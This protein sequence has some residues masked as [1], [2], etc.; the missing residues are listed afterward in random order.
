LPFFSLPADYLLPTAFRPVTVASFL[1]F[2]QPDPLFSCK[3][4]ASFLEALSFQPS[5]CPP[6]A[7]CPLPF[8]CLAPCDPLLLT[9]EKERKG[10]GHL[11]QGFRPGL[12]YF[13]APRLPHLPS[14]SSR[15]RGLSPGLPA[16][17]HCLL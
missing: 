16:G 17:C 12:H 4:V 15:Q 6:L 7:V 11:P 3:S 14:A 8:A 5:V 9:D 13:A 10:G 1:T 2:P